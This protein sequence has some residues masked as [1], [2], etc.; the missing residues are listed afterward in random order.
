MSFA[1]QQKLLWNEW[2]GSILSEQLREN[3]FFACEFILA[4]DV[5]CMLADYV[6]MH[7]PSLSDQVWIATHSAEL[8]QHR[9]LVRVANLLAQD[10]FQ[11]KAI[12]TIH[13]KASTVPLPCETREF[14]SMQEAMEWL[15]KEK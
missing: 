4:N 11:Q 14:L 2:R 7:A 6:K 8:L 9:K 3:I 10:V 5:E 13:E 12:E 15:L 1:K